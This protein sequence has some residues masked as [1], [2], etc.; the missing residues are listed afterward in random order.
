MIRTWGEEL[1]K[2]YDCYLTFSEDFLLK[3]KKKNLLHKIL[4]NVYN[5][6]KGIFKNKTHRY[7][8]FGNYTCPR[9]K[10]PPL[11]YLNGAPRHTKKAQLSFDITIEMSYY[12]QY[13]AELPFSAT[14]KLVG[15]YTDSF[16]HD[17]PFLDLK[18]KRDVR[19]LNR[20]EF[21]KEYLEKYDGIILG[22][23]NLV[24]QYRPLSDKLTFANGAYR[25]EDYIENNGV[26]M[27]KHLTIGW[28]GNP[29]R[30]MKGF[31]EVIEPTIKILQDSGL[32]IRLKTQFS[33]SF[34][35]LLS[36]YTDVDL[37]II[38][39]YADTSPSLF[40]EACLSNVP[41][42]S[43]EIGFPKMVIKN[44]VNGILVNRDINEIVKAVKDVYTDREKLMRF[45][46]RIKKDYLEVL[47][48]KI[49]INN[50]LNCLK[51][52]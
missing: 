51:S 31:R 39:S 8:L 27:H 21:Y 48:N 47:D 7:S 5:N 28:T 6:L 30:P 15:I 2:H 12:F 38:A 37:I 20:A 52:L 29:D 19:T 25:Q 22:N 42:I 36:F 9:Y 23:L 46:R 49:S 18:K 4:H 33:G 3:D 1:E 24:A 32:D 14:K 17:G 11:F 40:S 44:Q 45:S 41:C 34:E 43:T 35:S 16:P 50:L 26:G 10:K 13:T